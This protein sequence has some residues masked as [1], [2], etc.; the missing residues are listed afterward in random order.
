MKLNLIKS[1]IVLQM[2]GAFLITI[3]I[4][5]ILL[6]V[7]PK[8]TEI[9]KP[10]TTIQETV[11]KECPDSLLYE[12]ALEFNKQCEGFV[13]YRYRC[14]AGYL[15]IG[16][17]H[18]ILPGDTMTWLTEHQADSLL[19]LDINQRIYF[20]QKYHPNIEYNKQ[21]ALAWFIFGYGE[22]DLAIVSNDIE[23]VLKYKHYRENGVV[24]KSDL[25]RIR[26]KFIFDMYD[27]HWFK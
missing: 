11:K 25:L 6:Y 27:E 2:L 12:Y 18:M 17:G 8:E 10:L 13:P 1:V 24:K 5:C 4:F 7:F 16:Y 26:A 20:I 19:R 9:E 3:V 21:L 14:P 22:R 15:T 23:K